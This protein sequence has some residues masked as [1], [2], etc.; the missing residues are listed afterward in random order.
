ME[1]RNI[2]KLFERYLPY[3][4]ATMR[5]VVGFLFACHGAQKLFGVLGNSG[6]AA[7]T[8]SMPWFA[9]LIELLAGFLVLIGFLTRYAAL[10]ASVEMVVAYF[11]M[12]FQNGLWPISNG[13]E[14]AV[15]YCFI[16][17][18]IAT[19]GA[20]ACS[21]ETLLEKSRAVPQTKEPHGQA[22]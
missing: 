7:A 12:H 6:G 11:L 18:F 22:A 10:V 19:R 17:L 4:Y 14:L 5:V 21:V 8:F 9:G 3:L 2:G 13:G 15:L 16:F 20:W 1:G